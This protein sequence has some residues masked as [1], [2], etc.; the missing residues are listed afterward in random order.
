LINEG[1]F[2]MKPLYIFAISLVVLLLVV[3]AGCRQVPLAQPAASQ[4][5]P[6]EV[7][8][9]QPEEKLTTVEEATTGSTFYADNP[10]L[11]A[12]NR[13]PP[14]VV[15]ERMSESELFGANPELLKVRPPA[16]AAELTEADFLAANPELMAARRYSALANFYNANAKRNIEADAARYTGLATFYEADNPAGA[17]SALEVE[18]ARYQGLAEYYT[19]GNSVQP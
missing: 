12:A 16:A 17:V 15:E 10:E 8:V 9:P 7:A 1:S 3:L 5:G 14:A 6:V 11:M 2:K 19:R 13:Y 4:P 18:A